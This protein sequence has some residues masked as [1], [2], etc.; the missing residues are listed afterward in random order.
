MKTHR[1]SGDGGVQ[2]GPTEE[3]VF[4]T[5][6][7]RHSRRAGASPHRKPRQEERARRNLER[8]GFECF[9][10]VRR[11]ERIHRGCKREVAESL[12]PRYVFVRLS[13]EDNWHPVSSTL[14]VARIVPFGEYPLPVED[15]LFANIRRRNGRGEGLTK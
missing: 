15:E 6:S 13:L 5:W 10:P 12:F 11:V 3:I 2:G 9:R 8:Q 7:R 1:I 4:W 14:G